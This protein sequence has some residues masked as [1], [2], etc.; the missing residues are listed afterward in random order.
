MAKK[1]TQR[2]NVDQFHVNEKKW[3]K[4]LMDS[5]WSVLP[6]IIIEKQA[7]LG[8]DPMDMNIILHLVQYWWV[9]DNPPHPSVATI[10]E[11]ISVTPRTI[12]KRITAMTELG[13]MERKERRHTRRGSDTNLYSFDGLIKAVAPFAEEKL[14]KKAEA[15]AAEKARIKSKKPKLV[16]DNK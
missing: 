7:A 12:Q 8:L 1:T 10:A 9:A 16:V 14:A 2:Q 11:A 3:T 6:N 5:G 15:Q 4:P 13:L